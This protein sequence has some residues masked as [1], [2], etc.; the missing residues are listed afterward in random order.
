MKFKQFLN[1]S[2]KKELTFEEAKKIAD[3]LG[4]I[5]MRKKLYR[6]MSDGPDYMILNGQEGGRKSAHTTNY[7]TTIIDHLL[8]DTDYPLR[9]KSIIC[10]RNRVTA[11]GYGEV[12]YI[13]PLKDVK[14]AS[15]NHGD[16]WNMRFKT[17]YTNL[18]MVDF[19]DYYEECDILSK[20]YEKIIE[21]IKTDLEY[22]NK[23]YGHDVLK[24]T[25]EEPKHVEKR[26]KEMYQSIID[27]F[28]LHDTLDEVRGPYEYWIGG[29]CLAVKADAYIDLFD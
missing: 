13:F 19:N 15:T 20:S 26:L 1:E 18:H 25:F 14:I 8:K 24:A 11:E 7:Y 21:G 9:S 28:S 6:G 27:Q 10:T 23:S 22:G 29:P 12:Y 3:E 17:P 5:H 2:Y 4:M 16:I